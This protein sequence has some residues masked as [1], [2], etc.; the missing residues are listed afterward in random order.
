MGKC[1]NKLGGLTAKQRVETAA[2]VRPQE[3]SGAEELQH[4]MEGMRAVEQGHPADSL[5]SFS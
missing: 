4:S 5:E 3:A 1:F 2:G